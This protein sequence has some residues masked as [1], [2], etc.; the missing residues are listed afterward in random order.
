MKEAAA[1][2]LDGFTLR[3]LVIEL[4]SE[5]A[6]ARLTKIHQPARD[7]VALLMY[8]RRRDIRLV[9]SANP[10]WAR[11]SVET[12]GRD[13]P[14][15]PP[16]FCMILRKHLDGARLL[17]ITQDGLERIVTLTFGVR[18]EL[19]DSRQKRL[20]LE[21]MGRHSNLLLVDEQGTIIDAIRRVADD[22]A[23]RP[24]IPGARY[25]PPPRS[26]RPDALT[27]TR[28]EFAAALPAGPIA[29]ALLTGLFGLSP[30]LARE[31]CAR[32]QVPAKAQAETLSGQEIDQLFATLASLRNGPAELAPEAVT[33]TS[34]KT[35][36]SAFALTQYSSAP[37]RRFADV[38]SLVS[39]VLG[40]DEEQEAI[41]T[42]RRS[43]AAV[44]RRE[45]DRCAKKQA[46]Q[47]EE[48]RAGR[49][50]DDLRV[51]GELIL[52]NLGA[53][54]KRMTGAT[55]SD[56]EGNERTIALDPSRTPSE[57]AQAYFRRYARAKKAAVAAADHARETGEE[58]AYLE[59]VALG[60]EQAGDVTALADIRAELIGQGY[61]RATPATTRAT[62]QPV[63]APRQ[64]VTRDGR[65]IIVGRNNFQND[66]V[67][68]K[69]A[70]PGDIWLHVKDMP[71]SHV[72][73][74]AG[75]KPVDADA[76]EQAA[77]LAAYFSRGRGATK[78]AVDFTERRHVRKVPGA[79]PG[80]VIYD[81]Q[82]TIMAV[83]KGPA[84]P[85]ER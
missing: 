8:H 63:S 21:I 53:L 4:G 67:T 1:V 60:I 10:R 27:V 3:A 31:L 57:N 48:A 47:L 51:A 77:A 11:L 46:V 5:L 32:A 30:L 64:F 44:V 80:M 22:D 37:R 2:G 62:R 17:S 76:I 23:P 69:L 15:S 55:L 84:E 70:R 16:P 35:E 14:Q 79:R 12:G 20:L 61:L 13:N 85:D 75:D 40:G 73:L 66:L 26:D 82:Q 81:H 56:Y 54:K 43:L 34:G 68:M 58:L 72:I 71:G 52:A 65:E 7:Q 45:S 28:Q 50:A 78:V 33:L 39:D 9:L 49:Q 6:D 42:V 74:R 38:A 41:A 19:G 83:P 25:V 29:D 24:L 59:Q 36:F 18:D